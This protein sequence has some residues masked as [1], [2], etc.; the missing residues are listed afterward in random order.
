VA[1][2]Y[3]FATIWGHESVSY[4]PGRRPPSRGT[5]AVSVTPPAFNHSL[6]FGPPS[7]D[8]SKKVPH[9]FF[10]LALYLCFC[11]LTALPLEFFWWTLFCSFPY[12][13]PPPPLGVSSLCHSMTSP[14]DLL[15]PLPTVGGDVNDWYSVFYKVFFSPLSPPPPSH[16]S[17]VFLLMPCEGNC[18]APHGLQRL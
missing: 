18:R 10:L 6:S 16:F 9:F 13:S 11:G 4:G 5:P 7:S 1:Q 12:W 17:A 2:F 14:A 15:F 3:P 8:F